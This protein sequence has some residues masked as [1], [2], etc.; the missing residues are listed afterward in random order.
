MGTDR[1]SERKLYSNW[2]KNFQ[3]VNLVSYNFLCICRPK[4]VVAQF[5]DSLQA[6][7]VRTQSCIC[8]HMISPSFNSSCMSCMH[9]VYHVIWSLLLWHK[10]K[11]RKCSVIL[12]IKLEIFF[13]PGFI[14]DVVVWGWRENPSGPK[15]LVSCYEGCTPAQV[16]FWLCHWDSWPNKAFC[17]RGLRVKP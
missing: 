3:K 17:V 14:S 4:I 15:I 8:K 9:D 7:F 5:K 13:S 2:Q 12:L 1:R 10:N 6:A 16:W 11:S